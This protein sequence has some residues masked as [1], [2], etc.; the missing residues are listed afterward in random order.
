MQTPN[1]VNAALVFARSDPEE[2]HECSF[3]H[4]PFRFHSDR[5]LL[6]AGFC[7]V[8][9]FQR[10]NKLGPGCQCWVFG[11]LGWSVW[12]GRFSLQFWRIEFQRRYDGNELRWVQLGRRKFGRRRLRWVHD[13]RV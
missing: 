2:N 11:E 13:R 4:R 7:R 3:V 6:A 12:V 10:R 1:L 9:Q 5:S 8:Q